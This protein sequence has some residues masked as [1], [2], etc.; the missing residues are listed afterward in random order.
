MNTALWIDG[1]PHPGVGE[2]ARE[3]PARPD[4][5]VGAVRVADPALTGTAV[6]AAAAAFAPWAAVPVAERVARVTSA[7]VETSAANDVRGPLLSREL[8]KV[9][10]DVRG[11]LDFAH[12]L[13]RYDGPV[14]E[15]LGADTVLHDDEGTLVTTTDPYGVIAAI[16]PWNAPVIL[17]ALKVV[18][19]LMTGNTMVV[20][21]SPLAPLAVTDFLT[22]VARRLPDGVL[23]VVNGGADVGQALVADPRV[24][25]VSFTGGLATA[26]HIAASAA[27]HVRPTVMELGGNDA[28]IFLPDAPFDLPT[29]Q[30]AV[31][32]TFLTSGQVCMAI[33]RLLVPAA[34]RDEFVEAYREAAER[35][36]RVGDPLDATS[37]M[38]PVVS[39]EHQHRLTAL[40]D[41]AR[42]A[43]GT[44]LDVGRYAPSSEDGYWVRPTLVL[45]LPDAHPLVVDEQ[46]GPTVP[47]LTYDSVDEAVARANGVEQALASSV[48][49]ADTDR[50]VAVARRL[51]A[52]FTFINCH[53]RAGTSLRA[54]FGGRRS[55][56]HGRE[57]GVAG[58]AE[59]LQTHSINHPAAIRDNR[60]LGNAYPVPA[61]RG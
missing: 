41:S 48:W 47:L 13:A 49:S 34:R 33:K 51:D 44:V 37:T 16:T 25:K 1:A 18:P 21:P 35:V 56:G 12:A 40:V 24:A 11:E 10:A 9:I 6:A 17:A 59:Y 55:S 22:E 7:I 19:G 8:G 45:D 50:A 3:N 30:R 57:F 60:A 54:S 53:N 29:M 20:K 5:R 42:A 46:F 27:H 61:A 26:R 2:I 31:F 14:A 15:R 52:G 4:E 58:V 43:G 28:A 23:N 32:G 38:G 39:R 36:L